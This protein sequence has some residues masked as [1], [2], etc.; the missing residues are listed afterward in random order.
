MIDDGLLAILV[1]PE[2]KTPVRPA[3]L[4]EIGAVNRRFE[5][6]ALRNRSGQAVTAALTAGLVRRDGRY[7]YAI[8]D[9]IPVMLVDEAIP[10]A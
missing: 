8:R 4:E 6:G 7:L 2:N 10:L 5:A 3:T 9:D 1:C